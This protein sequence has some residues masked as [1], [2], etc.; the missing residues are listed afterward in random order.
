MFINPYHT[1]LT[2]IDFCHHNN[3]NF[4]L[5]MW[6][7]TTQRVDDI[8]KFVFRVLVNFIYLKKNISNLILCLFFEA[9][10][11]WNG[12]KNGANVICISQGVIIFCAPNKTN[13]K[14]VWWSSK[15]LHKH[16][17]VNGLFTCV[18]KQNH[19]VSIFTALPDSFLD[20]KISL[21]DSTSPDFAGSIFDCAHHLC[22]RA[23][24]YTVLYT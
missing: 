12:T 22:A 2:Y 1:V 14:K 9:I 17:N 8:C 4:I 10:F 13:E 23:A 18:Q 11:L 3:T 15:F 19:M 7:Q 16:S 24:C 5:R 20:I 21:L 6:K